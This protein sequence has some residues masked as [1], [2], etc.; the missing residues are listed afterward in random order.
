MNNLMLEEFIIEI[1]KD[2]YG[3]GTG[4]S[5][6]D[7]AI[8]IAREEAAIWVNNCTWH[9]WEINDTLMYYKYC[10]TRLYSFYDYRETDNN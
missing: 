8:E 1:P 7:Y 10:V 4:V 9:A 6:L 2:M 3:P 5:R